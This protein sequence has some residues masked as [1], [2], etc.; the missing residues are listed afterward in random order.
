MMGGAYSISAAQSIFTD[1]LIHYLQLNVPDIDPM[2]VIGPGA[3]QFRSTMPS[4]AISGIVLS[5]MRSLHIVFAFAIALAGIST[6]VG[7]FAKW[8][9]IHIRL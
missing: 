3:T 6:I 2:A 7:I 4:A 8:K 1:K 9:T 5:Y